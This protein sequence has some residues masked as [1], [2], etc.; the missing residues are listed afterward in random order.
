[1]AD[2]TSMLSISDPVHLVLIKTESSGETHLLSSHYLEWR[3]VLS[4]QASR[5]TCQLELMGTGRIVF[6]FHVNKVHV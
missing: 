2:K 3:T 5:R 1:M 6:T 4:D